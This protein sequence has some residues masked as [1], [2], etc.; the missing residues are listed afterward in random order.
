[1]LSL[2]ELTGK[3][4]TTK[5]RVMEGDIPEGD[6]IFNGHGIV[7]VPQ[8]PASECCCEKTTAPDKIVIQLE[9]KCRIIP[10]KAEEFGVL[11]QFASDMSP[12]AGTIAG[13]TLLSQFS[14]GLLGAM[15]GFAAGHMLGRNIATFSCELDDG[16]KFD[17]MCD[18]KVYRR[19]VSLAHE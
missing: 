5:I 13:I 19:L 3:L 8:K 14:F 10:R 17:G 7:L 18:Y 11:R 6:W 15:T 1:V 9:Q 4:D 16:R 12:L 2:A